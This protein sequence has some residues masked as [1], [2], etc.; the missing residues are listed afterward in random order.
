[1]TVPHP[2][3]FAA[4]LLLLSAAPAAAQTAD[5]TRPTNA[6]MRDIIV[7]WNADWGRA[8]LSG[9]TATLERMLPASYTAKFGDQT[10]SREEFLASAK[11]PPPEVTLTRFDAKVLTVQSDSTGWTATIEEKLEFTRRGENG[12][13]DHRSALWV[14]RD[15]WE[16]VNGQWALVMGEVV[17]NETWRNGAKPP[18]GDW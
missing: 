16:R 9:D 11:S 15:R 4:A 17:G 13:V 3:S 6:A 14:I 10:M 5:T 7:R 18:F 2:R 12:A 8:R 1:L